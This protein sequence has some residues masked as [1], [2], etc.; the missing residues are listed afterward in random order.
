MGPALVDDH[1]LAVGKSGVGYVL[2]A[3]RLGGVGGQL[4]SSR[5][6]LP[7]AAA[8]STGRPCTCRAATGP[9]RSASTAAEGSPRSGR[10][11]CCRTGRRS[12]GAARYGSPTIT[13]GCCTSSTLDRVRRV[14]RSMSANFRTSRPRRW[15]A[16]TST[17][18]P[19][20]GSSPSPL[21]NTVLTGIGDLDVRLRGEGRSN[22]P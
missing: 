15:P 22:H 20:T 18:A 5:S 2:D 7:T 1:V 16:A 10:Q 4:P 14:R 11:R 8:R 13:A 21:L 12:S 9:E 3:A 19:W 6:A 17:S